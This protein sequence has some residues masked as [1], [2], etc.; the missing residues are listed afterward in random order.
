MNAR[1]AILSK[2]R[3]LLAL[4]RSNNEHEAAAALARAQSIMQK[5]DIE[6]DMLGVEKP[7]EEVVD[8]PGDPLWDGKRRANWLGS[9]G[10]VLAKAN[11]CDVYWCGSILHIVGRRNDLARVRILFKA[12]TREIDSL[13]RRKTRG[14]G[15]R[16]A[17]GFRLGCVAAIRTAAEQERVRLR[18]EILSDAARQGRLVDAERALVRV[19]TRAQETREY[20]KKLN[21]TVHRIPIR[22]GH[23]YRHGLVAGAGLYGSMSH[24]KLR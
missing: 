12:G 18:D 17:N 1:E 7:D 13:T 4:T 21:L 5:H 9:L 2:V 19:D 10:E 22:D 23:A 3:K 14:L 8:P 24:G 6:E 20:M 11:G 15:K 16:Y